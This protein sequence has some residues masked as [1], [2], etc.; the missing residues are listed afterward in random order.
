VLEAAFAALTDKEAE[1]SEEA[2]DITRTRICDAEQVF[3]KIVEKDGLKDRS[4]LLALLELEKR[5]RVHGLSSGTS[6]QIS[7]IQLLWLTVE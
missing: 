4:G 3:L 7:P 2:L 6:W 1:P 5:S